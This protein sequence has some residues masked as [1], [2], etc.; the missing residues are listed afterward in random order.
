M[1]LPGSVVGLDFHLGYF[2]EI[3]IKW[4]LSLIKFLYGIFKE[5]YKL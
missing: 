2:E 5:T 4:I 1:S 3:K